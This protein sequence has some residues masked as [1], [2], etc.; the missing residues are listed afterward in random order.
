[1]KRADFAAKLGAGRSERQAS[2]TICERDPSMWR[3]QFIAAAAGSGSVFLANPDWGSQE[4]SEFDAL[5]RQV[6]SDWDAESGWLMIPTGGSAGRIKL[7]RHD[8]QSLWAAVHG[9]AAFFG[10]TT[11]NSVGVLPLHHVGGLMG[12]LRSALTDG[13]YVDADWRRVSAGDYPETPVPLSTIS[14][15]PT[16]LRRLLTTSAG[17]GWLQEFGQVLIGG[18]ALDDALAERARAAGVPLVPSYGS[19]ETAAMIAAQ[20]ADAFLSGQPSGLAPLP[21]VVMTCDKSDQLLVAGASLFRGYWPDLIGPAQV[22]ESGDQATWLEEQRFE[23]KGRLDHL[24]NTG[25]EKVNPTEVE[26]VLRELIGDD[27]IAVL[28]V[29]DES[30]GQRVVLV[31]AAEI[32]IDLAELRAKSRDR[33]ASYKWPKTAT[34]CELWPVNSVGKIDRGRLREVAAATDSKSS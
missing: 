29:P 17:T 4:R 28:G 31:H 21:H 27:R 32:L 8:H 23:I 15:V 10:E 24:I 7:A 5:C 16:Q 19:T 20:T 18:A 25:G 22:W 12:W 13:P 3:H 26:A 14:L 1:M 9:Y 30:W 33:L 34:P 6:P 11:I 2:V